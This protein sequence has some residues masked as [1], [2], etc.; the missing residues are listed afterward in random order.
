MPEEHEINIKCNI[1]VCMKLLTL[2]RIETLNEIGC[3]LE[4]L[5]ENG[6]EKYYL[7]LNFLSIKFTYFNV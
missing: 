6:L 3:S 5:E 1:N 4:K 7:P 2:H